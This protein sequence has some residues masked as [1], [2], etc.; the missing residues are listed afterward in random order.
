MSDYIS[1]SAVF[2]VM[3]DVFNSYG[4]NALNFDE[5]ETKAIKRFCAM[6]QSQIAELPSVDE[7]EIIRKPMERI[8]ER[9]EEQKNF[10][11]EIYEEYKSKT[12]N[13]V[14]N[15]IYERIKVAH[16]KAIEAYKYAIKVVLEE[17]NSNEST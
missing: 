16:D 5:E 15:G 1:K 8:M 7:K 11:E 17:G 12:E 14:L 2:A 13:S 6:L 4:N 9:L 10:H 3:S